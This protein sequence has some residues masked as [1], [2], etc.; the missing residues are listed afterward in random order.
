MSAARS[1]VPSRE[2]FTIEVDW[3]PEPDSGGSRGSYDATLFIPDEDGHDRVAG[4]GVGGLTAYEA[5][6]AAIR[7][8][9]WGVKEEAA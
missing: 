5:G 7:D 6:C 9:G 3:N 2:Y 1:D 8:W 4:T